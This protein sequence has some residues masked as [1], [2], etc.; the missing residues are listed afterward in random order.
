MLRSLFTIPK[1]YYF[2]SV[3]GQ[4]QNTG[5]FFF[6]YKTLECEEEVVALKTE[7]LQC[8]TEILLIQ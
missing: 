8:M 5:S 6:L 7:A 1:G 2:I 4:V 3:A